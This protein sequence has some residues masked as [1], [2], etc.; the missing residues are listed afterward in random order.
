MD[1]NSLMFRLLVGEEK[2]HCSKKWTFFRSGDLFFATDSMIG[3]VKMNAGRRGKSLAR[4]FYVWIS[5]IVLV[6]FSINIGEA[7]ETP[8]GSISGKI[9]SD[10]V[11]GIAGVYA[12]AFQLVEE[13]LVW[14]GDAPVTTESG[15]YKIEGFEGE[16]L[17]DG[18]YFVRFWAQDTDFV[19]R[20]Y[21]DSNVNGVDYNDATSVTVS[22]GN[23][24]PG[25]DIQLSLG[26]S[27]SGKVV[28]DAGCESGTVENLEIKVYD[29]LGILRGFTRTLASGEFTVTG[30]PTE[31]MKILIWDRNGSQVEEW[32]QDASDSASATPVDVPS[33]GGITV[34]FCSLKPTVNLAPVYLLLL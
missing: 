20:W 5:A 21:S 10:G 28:K 34:N 15:I 13:N 23:D 17:A 27:I 31:Q 12:Q 30:L 16:G 19:T 3:G 7:E 14:K 6:S 24:T 2:T 22:G 11:T 33:T 26:G 9:T 32:Y 8:T 4:F 1:G 25:I 29:A 18:E